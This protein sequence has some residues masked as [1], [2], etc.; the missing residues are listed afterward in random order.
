MPRRYIGILG[1]YCEQAPEGMP[2]SSKWLLPC[3]NSDFGFPSD[4]AQLPGS[5]HVIGKEANIQGVDLYILHEGIDFICSK[6]PGQ[7]V[8]RACATGRVFFANHMPDGLFGKYLCVNHADG[9]TCSLYSHFAHLSVHEGDFVKEG[10]TL[11]EA[12][13]TWFG[14][15]HPGEEHLH[16]ELRS[17]QFT[18]TAC[19]RNDTLPFGLWPSEMTQRC[20][21]DLAAWRS[22][23][24]ERFRRLDVEDRLCSGK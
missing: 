2:H 6:S 10:Q 23:L 5:F 21:N 1:Y 9:R 14:S 3:V 11:G 8:W 24:K 20:E 19:P 13:A 17:G 7:S 22:F 15:N 18:S 4:K 16:F 12:G